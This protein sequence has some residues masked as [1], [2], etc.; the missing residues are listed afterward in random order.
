[1]IPHSIRLRHPWEEVSAGDGRIVFRRRFNKPTGLDDS[2]RVALEV[3]RTLLAADIS[4]NGTPL[5]QLS[6]GQPF[7][8]DITSLLQPAN[9]LKVDAD[10]H[11]ALAAPPPTSSIYIVEP[12]EPLG[13]PIGDVRLLIRTIHPSDRP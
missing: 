10:P 2:Q 7:A 6:P 11:T 5:G 1:M 12:D 9:E 13:S 3:D 4:L 8:A